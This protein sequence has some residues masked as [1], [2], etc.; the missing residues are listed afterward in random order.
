MTDPE[1]QR[2]DAK[3][4]SIAREVGT[5]GLTAWLSAARSKAG[6][7]TCG[8][9]RMRRCELLRVVELGEAMQDAQEEFE[10]AKVGG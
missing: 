5:L 8:S 10:R 9:D 2:V 6:A 1:F 7:M 3:L 4:R